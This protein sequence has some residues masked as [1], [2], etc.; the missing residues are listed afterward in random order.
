MP[1]NIRSSAPPPSS[2]ADCTTCDRRT[3]RFVCAAFGEK[4]EQEWAR[5]SY[6]NFQPF[7]AVL[8]L[9]GQ[10]AHGAFLLCTGHVKLSLERHGKSVIARIARA[11]ELLGVRE[12]LTG[13]AYRYHAEALEPCE[14]RF[15]P[16][17]AFQDLMRRHPE[18]CRQVQQQLASECDSADRLRTVTMIDDIGVRVAAFLL[19]LCD[20]RGR[21][22]THG[23]RFTLD[24]SH[25]EIGQMIG[26]ARETVTRKLSALRNA[27]LIATKGTTCLVPDRDALER[28]CR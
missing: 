21:Q 22:T 8:F 12:V 1:S 25:R 14:L 4:L 18:L 17:A 26:L 28:Y 6:P 24:I 20:E 16:A 7:G 10:P 13:S 5:G 9:Q 11:G 19:D 23:V 15:M 2:I 3:S 27:G